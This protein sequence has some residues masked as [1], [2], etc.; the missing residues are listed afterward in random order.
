MQKSAF[1]RSITLIFNR[2]N[3]LGG[4]FLYIWYF[5]VK[6]FAVGHGIQI[7][8]CFLSSN[9]CSNITWKQSFFHVYVLCIY[10]TEGGGHKLGQYEDMLT[11]QTQNKRCF[12]YVTTEVQLKWNITQSAYHMQTKH[13]LSFE[14]T[15]SS[16]TV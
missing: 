7:A 1:F 13:N 2:G 12:L 16:S 5:I 11:T 6:F 10:L 15:C 8:V 9:F 3:K 14:H 4:M